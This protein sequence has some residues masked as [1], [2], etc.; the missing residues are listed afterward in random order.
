MPAMRL[1]LLALTTLLLLSACPA[2]REAAPDHAG[3]S[4]F[5]PAAPIPAE[6]PLLAYDKLRLGMS[7][8]DISQAYNA[9][10]GKGKGFTRVIEDYGDAKNQIIQFDAAEGSPEQRRI[11]MRVY[12]DQAC[13]IVDRR[14]N[15]TPA[16]ADAWFEALKKQYG[17]EPRMTVAG[18]Q[19]SWGD[20]DAVLLTF[21]RDNYSDTSLSANVVLVHRPTYEASTNYTAAWL[22]EHP[23]R[24]GQ[25][26]AEAGSGMGSGA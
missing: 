3:Q 11:V 13:M 12:R 26:P 22:K 19:W 4:S 16:Q 20:K 10:R 17:A 14:D 8:L 21:T 25:G 7:N 2:R 18:A 24:A 6:D 9:P 1:G 23:E 15:I 5:D